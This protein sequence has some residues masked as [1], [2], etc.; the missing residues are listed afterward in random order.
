VALPVPEPG[1]VISY[2]YLWHQEF[3][4]GFEEGRKDRPAVIVLCVEQEDTGETVVTVV[5]ITHRAPTAAGAIQ[6][7]AAIK[8]HLGLDSESSWVVVTEI[9]EFRWPGYDLRTI[10]RAGGYQYGFLPPRFFAR[11]KDAMDACNRAGKSR[12][13]PRD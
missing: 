12:R 3:E 7:P 1:L 10:P 5:P 4:L 8:R 13:V 6:I 2:S 9:N 11:I